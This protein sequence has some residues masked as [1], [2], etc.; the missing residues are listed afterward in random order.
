M[1]Y[2]YGVAMYIYIFTALFVVIVVY[3]VNTPHGESRAITFVV[4]KKYM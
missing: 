4:Y 1:E 2:I 3:N